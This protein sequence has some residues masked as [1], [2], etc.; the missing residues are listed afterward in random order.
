MALTE[1]QKRNYA[2]AP[3]GEITQH[4]L[5]LFHGAFS[6]DWHLSTWHN[7]FQANVRGVLSAFTFQPFEVRLPARNGNGQQDLE[8]RTFV[9]SPD[10]LAE[11]RAAT[12]VRSEGIEIEYNRYFPD[13]ANA[14]ESPIIL[15]STAVA[16]K[17]GHVILVASRAD[18]LNRSFPRV[19]F[20][21]D[22]YQGNDR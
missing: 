20:R 15:N 5:S 10:F 19:L 9:T 1:R 13:D 3:R 7:P 4:C 11:L 21:T 17:G 6:H 2:S 8:I 12:A 18:M 16:I 14:A 22:K